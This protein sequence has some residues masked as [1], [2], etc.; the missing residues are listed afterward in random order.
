M[1][2]YMCV[3]RQTDPHNYHQKR[4]NGLTMYTPGKLVQKKVCDPT[5]PKP[6]R[7]RDPHV[8]I[9]VI[10]NTVVLDAWTEVVSVLVTDYARIRTGGA[11]APIKLLATEYVD[12]IFKPVAAGGLGLLFEL[13]VGGDTYDLNYLPPG[14]VH[15][16]TIDRK[17]E[18]EMKVYV[19]S[20]AVVPGN[21]GDLGQVMLTV[22][23]VCIPH[24]AFANLICC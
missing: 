2:P 23:T 4:F 1:N 5:C 3:L 14:I 24:Y 10:D 17:G 9:G 19:K 21:L 15:E 11:S 12:G 6:L 18:F 7:A 16:M 13:R 8:E 22:D 20:S